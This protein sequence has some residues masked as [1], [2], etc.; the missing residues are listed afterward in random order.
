MSALILQ[1]R[2]RSAFAPGDVSFYHPRWICPPHFHGQLEVCVITRGELEVL[3]GAELLRVAAPAL[4]WHPPIVGHGV[5]R[6]SPDLRFWTVTFEPELLSRCPWLGAPSAVEVNAPFAGWIGQFQRTI[7]QLPVFQI[8]RKQA[9]RLDELCEAGWL[10]QFDSGFEQALGKLIEAAWVA[11]Q[12][13][14]QARQNYALADLGLGVILG[15][16]DHDHQR[17]CRELLVSSS[18][19]ARMFRRRWDATFIE[20]RNRARAVTFLSLSRHPGVNLT[21]CALAAG[22]GSYSQ[23]HRVFRAVAGRSPSEYVGGG[24]VEQALCDYR[25][26]LTPWA[27]DVVTAAR[28][29]RWRQ[30]GAEAALADRDEM[31]V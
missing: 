12:S 27:L 28:N 1:E 15:A 30:P 16:P 7:G 24:R 6:V 9:W 10:A 21:A 20:L 11:T 14:L 25:S 13:E 2:V 17:I 4:V 18:Y 29:Y 22:F 5:T 26:A 31:Y 19:S 23:A 3:L 8:S